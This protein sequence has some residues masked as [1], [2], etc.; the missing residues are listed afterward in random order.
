[1]RDAFTSGVVTA[2]AS[3]LTLSIRARATDSAKTAQRLR[4]TAANR[5]S[6]RSVSRG[7]SAAKET[8]LEQFK[9][10]SKATVDEIRELRDVIDAAKDEQPIQK[11]IEKYP[12]ILA[13]LLG[14]QRRF[15]VPQP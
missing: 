8:E 1:M 10:T 4:Q 6:K 9:V 14:G 5:A 15:V 13:S 12:Q 11:F 7:W 2:L 3:G